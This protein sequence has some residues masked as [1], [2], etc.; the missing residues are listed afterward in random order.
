MPEPTTPL[1]DRRTL[2]L[3]S[4]AGMGTIVALPMSAVAPA[5]LGVLVFSLPLL[6]AVLARG[7]GRNGLMIAAF[8]LLLVLAAA[9]FPT[10]IPGVDV[11]ATV[12]VLVGPII[13]VVLVGA[14]LRQHDVPAAAGF[15][16]A[17]T[18]A[19]IGGFAASGTQGAAGLVVGLALIGIVIVIARLGRR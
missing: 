10:G 7:T 14:P 4:V 6:L 8:V 3:A 1:L 9:V 19:I 18:I 16:G 17:G 12:T 15:L 5:T 11:I 13:A 2:I